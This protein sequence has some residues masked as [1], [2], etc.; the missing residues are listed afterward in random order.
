MR[1]RLRWLGLFWPARG[2]RRRET[3]SLADAVLPVR[4]YERSAFVEW[5]EPNRQSGG[6]EDYKAAHAR[7]LRLLRENLTPVQR[8]QYE[9]FGYFETVG[10]QTGRRYR[11]RY[12]TQMNVE[13]LGRSGRVMHG[14][15]FVPEGSL[16]AGDV[17]LAQKLA[18]ELFEA[19]ALKVANKFCAG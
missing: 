11:I 8:A 6:A 16:V 15:C 14:L 10:G 7:G 5:A 4:A 12:G 9:N 1:S 17:M 13:R 18:L 2:S 19:D 3:V